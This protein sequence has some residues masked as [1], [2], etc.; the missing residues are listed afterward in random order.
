LALDDYAA[1]E[2]LGNKFRIVTAKP[3]AKTFKAFKAHGEVVFKKLPTNKF[4]PLS[5]LDKVLDHAN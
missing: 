1:L 2:I 4:L 3:F 5:E